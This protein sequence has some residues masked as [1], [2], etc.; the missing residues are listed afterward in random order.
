[1]AQVLGQLVSIGLQDKQ[2]IDLALSLHS[3]PNHKQEHVGSSTTH[4][5]LNRLAED[6]NQHIELAKDHVD[7]PDLGVA[8]NSA[9]VHRGITDHAVIAGLVSKAFPGNPLTFVGGKYPPSLHNEDLEDIR[10]MQELALARKSSNSQA[11]GG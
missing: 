3:K 8:R 10:E 11:R 4:G 2:I 7:S 9:D 5:S 1:M 6:S